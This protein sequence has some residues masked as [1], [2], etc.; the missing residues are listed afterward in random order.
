MIW[1]FSNYVHHI[2]PIK[3]KIKDIA[4]T[5]RSVSYLDIHLEI[6]SYG[7]SRIDSDDWLRTKLYDKKIFKFPHCEHSIYMQEHSI[8]PAHGVYISEFMQ[9]SRA[10]GSWHN[11]LDIVMLLSRWSLNWAVPISHVE[12]LSPK[13]LR[14]PPW[15]G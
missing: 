14:S 11:C 5:A 7:K 1:T 9:Y 2:Y 6:D 13:D 10:C 8:K 3:L 15:L 12:D 4:D